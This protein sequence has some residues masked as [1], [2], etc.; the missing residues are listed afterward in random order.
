VKIDR[1][2]LEN[3]KPYSKISLPAEGD[4][5]RGL[6]LIEGS[7]STGKTSLVEAV[8]WVLWGPHAIPGVKQEQLVRNGTN[9]CLVKLRFSVAGNQF[10]VNRRYRIGSGAEAV[11]LEGEA[12]VF[13]PIDRGVTSVEAKLEEI[14]G[15]GQ[16]DALQT[17]FVRQGEVDTLSNATPGELRDLIR[18]LF[19][20]DIFDEISDELKEKADALEREIHTLEKDVARKQEIEKKRRT[21]ENEINAL[22]EELEKLANVRK[23]F[24]S[25]LEKIPEEKILVKIDGIQKKIEQL[26]NTVKEINEQINDLDGKKKAFEKGLEKYPD[27]NII[28]NL[29]SLKYTLEQHITQMKILLE[30]IKS[31]QNRADIINEEIFKNNKEYQEIEKMILE[32]KNMLEGLPDLNL[33]QEIEHS[34]QRIEKLNREIDSIGEKIK[35]LIAQRRIFDEEKNSDLTDLNSLSKKITDVKNILNTLPSIE[36]L[37]EIMELQEPLKMSLDHQKRLT[38]E[39]RREAEKLGLPSELIAEPER[40]SSLISKKETSLDHSKETEE[41]LRINYNHIKEREGYLKD[42]I[43]EIETNE[44]ELADMKE[45][46]YCFKSITGEDI[47]VIKEHMIQHKKELQTELED[48]T[49]KLSRLEQEREDVSGQLERLSSSIKDL[50]GFMDS[51]EALLKATEETE[52][53]AEKLDEF[54]RH[55]GYESLEK[56]L[57]T[58]DEKSLES[59]HSNV[60]SLNSSVESLKD[61]IK[62]LEKRIEDRE[63]RILELKEKIAENLVNQDNKKEKLVKEEEKLEDLVKRSGCTSLEEILENAEA[64]DPRALIERIESINT[65]IKIWEENLVSLEERIE[66]QTERLA[67]I[68]GEE[69]EA[70]TK[71]KA[72]EGEIETVQNEIKNLLGK[73]GYS[74]LEELLEKHGVKELGELIG[75]I[76]RLHTQLN[77]AK[78]NTDDLKERAGNRRKEKNS[79]EKKL[80]ETLK[81]TDYESVEKMLLSLEKKTVN[82]LLIDRKEKETRLSECQ[83]NVFDRE[84]RMEERNQRLLEVQQELEELEE[85]ENDIREKKKVEA[86]ASRLRFFVDDFVSEYVIRERL[87][88]TLKETV[89]DYLA[90]F[91]KGRYIV[92][93]LDAPSS[94]PYGAGVAITLRDMIQNI[95]KPRE[96]LSGGDKVSLGLAL[97]IA[98]A[99]LASRIRPFKSDTIQQSKVR[100]L[101]M[102]EPLGSLDGERRPQVVRTLLSTESFDQIFLITHADPGLDEEELLESNRI[103]VYQRD[104]ESGISIRLKGGL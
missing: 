61:R 41:S 48:I 57:E 24:E 89:A 13:H 80:S 19:R 46:P 5:P 37:K 23:N 9:E 53:R 16:D 60:T 20:L 65:R 51:T 103:Q 67:E 90:P 77:E 92:E 34:N 93:D 6:F 100:C 32:A 95:E 70:F 55:L 25:D 96:L 76:E 72:L 99:F 56:L 85:K 26:E 68:K 2:E 94:G 101:I 59:V 63:T 30:G 58:A 1:L 86:H 78:K 35:G 14:L 91:S 39:N 74:A 22:K 18:D 43:S 31:L 15:L 33:A 40:V 98:I 71:R 83:K 21:L 27:L 102:D 66:D 97:R 10:Q 84:E 8:L 7:N 87:C 75:S 54:V 81:E 79:E 3:F 104:G 62:N 50:R 11:L 44:T 12:G 64:R 42:R 47:P 4:L 38:V 17:V 82:E 88:G 29:E 36:E 45:C 49:S 69:D 28:K 73:V 52:M